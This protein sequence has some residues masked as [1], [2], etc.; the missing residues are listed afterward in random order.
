MLF[1]TGLINLEHKNRFL[2]FK[3]ICKIL[4]VQKYEILKIQKM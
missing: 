4:Q 2:I 3:N 1:L